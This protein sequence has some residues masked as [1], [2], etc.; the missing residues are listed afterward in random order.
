MNIYFKNVNPINM[1]KDIIFNI[2]IGF[3][4]GLVS[5]FF[6][7]G[8]GMLVVPYLVEIVKLDEVKSRATSI[9]CI[10]FMVLTSAF[11]YFNQESIDWGLG[12][13]CAI[14]GIIGSYI[15][16][17]FLLKIDEK[18]IKI[19]FIIFLFYVGLSMIF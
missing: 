7:A 14:G 1:K 16:S 10:F 18:K 8:G 4:A 3:F 19:F 5:G 2:L 12:V 15:G 11:Y 17:K 9:L 6:G 13:K